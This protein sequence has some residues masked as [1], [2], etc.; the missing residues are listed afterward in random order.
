M[1]FRL[2]LLIITILTTGILGISVYIR[3][4]RSDV[5]LRFLL[6]IS[7]FVFWSLA[8][9]VIYASA[10]KSTVLFAD[11]L[12]YLFGLG[13]AW[14]Y[15]SFATYFPYLY[16]RAQRRMVKILAA[17]SVVAG[18]V[19]LMPSLL[20]H[21]VAIQTNG[22]FFVLNF[23]GFTFYAVVFFAVFIYAFYILA[24]KYRESAGEH[25]LQ[26]KYVFVSSLVPVVAGSIF[27]VLFIY[28]TIFQYQ[29]YGPSFTLV[30]TITVTYLLFRK[31]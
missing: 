5:A 29:V 3:N 4:P 24:A 16:S 20:V 13:I 14:A 10:D 7:L 9:Y 31:K 18:A 26:I 15:L 21:D 28:F 19:S 22:P 30:F 25:K 1:D 6:L 23:Y 17:L 11:R 2:I 27:N 12:T 8:Q